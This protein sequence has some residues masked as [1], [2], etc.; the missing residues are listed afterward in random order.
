M[1]YPLAKMR[2]FAHFPTPVF[3]LAFALALVLAPFRAA[4]QTPAPGASPVAASTSSSPSAASQA[5]KSEE[6][7]EQAFLHSSVVQSLARI[8]HLSLDTTVDLLLG[9]NFAIIFFAILIPLTKLMPKIVRKR[10]QTL[11]HDFE[12]AREATAEAQARLNAVEA[13]LAGL[14]EEIE[15]FRA[16]VEQESLEDEQRIK[17]ALGE[18]SARIVAA[19]EQEIEVAVAQARRG[20]R[21]FAADLA[22]DQAAKQL[23]LSPETDRAL[24][25]EFIAGAAADAS[26]KGGS[27]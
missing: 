12:T 13:K 5:P 14:G 27:N 15:K 17:A 3:A 6:E 7:Q 20:L 8:L 25:A 2:R 11:R 1:K 10:S 4:A 23:S 26:G 18:E 21:H 22:I 16:Q 24:I 19:A 9:I